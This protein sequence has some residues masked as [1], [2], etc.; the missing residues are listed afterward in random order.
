LDID[1][2]LAMIREMAVNRVVAVGCHAAGEV[3][4]A[5]EQRKTIANALWVSLLGAAPVP[6]DYS[7]RDLIHIKAPFRPVLSQLG[8]ICD[9]AP[10]FPGIV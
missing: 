5:V 7:H 3:S 1:Q 6:L 8:C 9:P 10:L 2:S 4:D